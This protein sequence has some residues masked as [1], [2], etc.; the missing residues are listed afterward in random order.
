MQ[1]QLD[2]GRSG[3]TV[4][5][6][7]WAE[8]VLLETKRNPAVANPSAAVADALAAPIGTP[9][10]AVLAHGKRRAVVVVSDKTR[11]VP[12]RVLLPPLL[13]TLRD[14]GLPAEQVEILVATGLHRANTL[15][16]LEEML[17]ADVVRTY[18]VR[19]HVARDDDA[20]EYLGTTSRGTEIWIDRGYL[21]ADL[22]IL[23]GL[24]EPHLM[25][26][27][28]G[29]RKALCPGLAGVRTMRSAHGPT[30][31]EGHVGPGILQGNPFHEDLLEI[32]ARVGA[33]FLCD[34]TID[35]MRRMTGVYAGDVVQAHLAGAEALE[36]QVLVTLPESV[37]I[38]LTS[39]GGYPLDQTLYQA[40]KGL[41]AALNIVRPGGA[42]VLVAELSEG[43]GSAEFVRLLLSASSP[44]AFMQQLLQ[45]GFFQVDQ[46]MVQ[47]LCQ[48]LRKASVWIVSHHKVVEFPDGFAIRWAASAE[49]ALAEIKERF[50]QARSV[51]VI[52]EGP[53]TL[54]T[55][56]GVKMP[57][58]TA[59]KQAA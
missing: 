45:P 19:N 34:V 31:L 57:L 28:S 41:V 47:H 50:P 12:Y 56:R 24:I 23:T 11:P 59:W 38:V 10:L 2:F 13:R 9:P 27:Y 18:P 5:L 7:V 4:A 29:G 25:A 58:G 36:Q 49:A 53:Y 17:G 22:R 1:V 46:W 30:M 6:P 26:G 54:P 48:V 15:A 55:V 32:V 8:A 37:D 39:A 42:I 35:R 44:D 51:A 16:E 21:R 43:A 52:P 3:I 40:I 20:H 14:A 33:D